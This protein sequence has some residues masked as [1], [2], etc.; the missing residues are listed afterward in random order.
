MTHIT[1]EGSITEY[2]AGHLNP[3]EA[4][5]LIKDPGEY[6]VGLS[7][8]NDILHINDLVIDEKLDPTAFVV[9]SDSGGAREVSSGLTPLRTKKEILESALFTEEQKEA[10]LE[11]SEELDPD[12]VRATA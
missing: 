7:Q 1:F 10:I 3:D 6:A 8:N 12:Q 5:E 2:V 11:M 4:E 9:N